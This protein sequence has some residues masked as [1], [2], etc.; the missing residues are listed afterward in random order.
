MCYIPTQSHSKPPPLQNIFIINNFK[1]LK[2]YI[3]GPRRICVQN[4]GQIGPAVLPGWWD[5]HTYTLT[6][7]NYNFI[8]IDW[9]LH[10][11]R[12][13]F[14]MHFIWVAN[15]ENFVKIHTFFKLPN[16]HGVVCLHITLSSRHFGSYKPVKHSTKVETVR[17]SPVNL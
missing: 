12:H 17:E 13:K 7:R 11:L 9:H 14:Q 5:I 8:Y 3:S 2:K 6:Y 1:P 4:L 10:N 16:I 15:I